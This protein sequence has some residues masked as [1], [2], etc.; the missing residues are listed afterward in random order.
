M[1]PRHIIRPFFVIASLFLL[2]SIPPHTAL[3]QKCDISWAVDADGFW[4][5]ASHWDLNRAPQFGER[6]CIDRPAGDFTI[7]IRQNTGTMESVQSN[8]TLRLTDSAAL[9][10]QQLSMLNGGLLMQSGELNFQSAGEY[11]LYG[12]SIWSG[13][14]LRAPITNRGT[15]TF[16][17]AT[18]LVPRRITLTNQ[19]TIV[20]LDGAIN[21]SSGAGGST[22]VNEAGALYDIRSGVQF[23]GSGNFNNHGTLRKSSGEDEAI[24]AGL[25]F[26]NS[27]EGVVDVQ[28]G[29]LVFDG[30]GRGDG[31]TFTVAENAVLEWRAWGGKHTGLFTGSGDGKIQITGNWEAREEGATLDF[32]AGMLEW[33]AGTIGG[34]T[35][36]GAGCS[37]DTTNAGF[38]TLVGDADKTLIRS[39][40]NTGTIIH[41]GAGN[42][43]LSTFGHG[44]INQAEGL[45][46]LR[47]DADILGGSGSFTNRGILRKTGGSGE[48]RI[49]PYSL[50]NEGGTIDVQSGILN[51][52]SR[53]NS[54]GGHFN[55]EAGA[56]LEFSQDVVSNAIHNM[57]GVYTGAGA[58]TVRHRGYIRGDS[59]NPAVLD[60]PPGMF[61][62]QSGIVTGSFTNSGYFNLVGS[63]PKYFR[64]T[65]VNNGHFLI[66]GEGDWQFYVDAFFTNN[67]LV[68]FQSD[69]NVEMIGVRC[70]GCT[71]TIR[72]NGTLRKSAGA[73]A[74]EWIDPNDY[75]TL[76]LDNVGQVE[77]MSGSLIVRENVVQAVGGRL[78]G[79][80][81][82]ISSTASFDMPAMGNIVTNE[83]NVTLSGPGS[84]FPQINSLT[85]N[86]GRFA[87]DGPRAFV[88]ASTLG[89]Q[90]EL[91]LGAG[92]RLQVTGNYTA[93]TDSQ[94]E[95][96]ITGRPDSGDFGQI[97]VGGQAILDGRLWVALDPGFAPSAGDRYPILTFGERQGDF[98]VKSGLDPHFVTQME[99]DRLLLIAGGAPQPDLAIE[100]VTLV[101]RPSRV[102]ETA[103]VDF[104]VHNLGEALATGEWTDAL[105][106][107][108][109]AALDPS[110]VLLGSLPR[111]GE[112]AAGERYQARIEAPLPSLS[113]GDFHVIAVADHN[114]QVPDPN[115][116]NNRGVAADKIS[117][118]IPTLAFDTILADAIADGQ[119]KYYRLEVPQGGDVRLNV[120]FQTL[121]AAEVYVRRAALPTRATW[122]FT[123]SNLFETERQIV[124]ESPAAGAYYI[125]VYGR[126]GAA[127]G[128][129]LTL[130]ATRVPFALSRIEPLNGSNYGE[131]TISLFGSEFTEASEVHLLA[132]GNTLAAQRIGLLSP[133]R[134]YATFDL[135]DAPTGLY[136]V[137]VRKGAEVAILESRFTVEALGPLGRLQVT[138]NLPSSMRPGRT[139][140]GTIDYRNVGKTD[141]VSP[142][143]L[144]RSKTDSPFNLDQG[145]GTRLN[146]PHLAVFAVSPF[147]PAGI[148]PPGAG[149]T[150][151]VRINAQGPGYVELAAFVA[152]VED[153]SPTVWINVLGLL[154]PPTAGPEWAEVFAERISSY[155]NHVGAYVQAVGAAAELYQ[156]RT[157]ERTHDI[158]R[159]I[160]FT[161]LDGIA[162]R[163]ANLAGHVYLNDMTQPLGKTAVTAVERESGDTFV[164]TTYADGL[165]RFSTLPPGVY[166]LNFDGVLPP[167]NLQP[168]TITGGISST[169]NIWVTRPGGSIVGRIVLPVNVPDVHEEAYAVAISGDLRF[170]ARIA[171]NGIFEI[172]GL[173]SG[174]YTVEAGSPLA[175]SV[176][177]VEVAVTAPEEA[178]VGALILGEVGRVAGRITNHNGA[179]L[180]GAQIVLAGPAFA[181]STVSD[182]D[183]RYILAGAPVGNHRIAAILSP[184]LPSSVQ[185]VVTPGA[186]TQNVDIILAPAASVVGAIS[187]DSGPVARAVVN[188]WQGG[189]VAGNALSD[190]EG[191]YHFAAMTAGAYTLTVDAFAYAAFSTP[192]QLTANQTTTTDVTLT[193]SAVIS[194]R[195]VEPISGAALSGVTVYLLGED[196]SGQRMASDGQGRFGFSRLAPGA[197]AV[198]LENGAARQTLIV[199]GAATQQITLQLA[200]SSLRGQV[201]DGA[202]KPAPAAAVRLLRNGQEIVQTVTG[203]GGQYLFPFVAPGDY[204]VI[205]T[206]QGAVELVHYPAR[207]LRVEAGVN[208]AAPDLQPGGQ[209]LTV[210]IRTPTNTLVT[211]GDLL[212][213]RVLEPGSTNPVELRPLAADGSTLLG[214]LPPG[215]YLLRPLV[216]GWAAEL[217]PVRVDNA[218]V[219]LAITLKESAMLFGAVS[220]GGNQ[221]LAEIDVA[222]YD[223]AQPAS[224]YRAR[225]D[226][227]GIYRMERMP[228]GSYTVVIASLGE[229]SE[230]ADLIP[231]TVAG[232]NLTAGTITE[233]SATLLPGDTRIGGR[234]TGQ[235]GALPLDAVVTLYTATGIVVDRTRAA[236]DGQFTLAGVPPGTFTVTAQAAGYAIQPR[237][238]TVASGQQISDL[239]LQAQWVAWS[240]G[241]GL[242]DEAL[243]A[244]MSRAI[245]QRSVVFR[246][247]RAASGLG[248]LLITDFD[249][250]DWSLFNNQAAA[251]IADAL[252]RLLRKPQAAPHLQRPD[253]LGECQAALAAWRETQ[254]WQNYA[255]RFFDAWVQDWEGVV[256]SNF[257]DAAIMAARGLQLYFTW[258]TLLNDLTTFN[259]VNGPVIQ[260][261]RNQLANT[262]NPATQAA[263]KNSLVQLNQAEVV[264]N[265]I[266]SS[267]VGFGA[268]AGLF[269]A[270]GGAGSVLDA[271]RNAL[272]QGDINSFLRLGAQLTNAAALAGSFADIILGVTRSLPSGLG[273]ALGSLAVVADTVAD[274]ADAW[275]NVTG[276]TNRLSGKQYEYDRAIQKRNAAYQKVLA[277]LQRCDEEE[278]EEPEEPDDEVPPCPNCPPN[279]RA[280]AGIV[281]SWDPNEK[282][283]SGAG[284][285]AHNESQLRFTRPGE[286]INY[287]VYFENLPTAS[288]SAQEV[289]IFDDLDANLDLSTFELGRF[290]FGG[291]EVDA[292]AGRA[293][294][295]AQVDVRATYSL[296]VN[297]EAELDPV[298]RRLSMT[299]R[300]VDPETG[301]LPEDAL[302]GFLPPNDESGRGEGFVSFSIAPLASLAAGAMIRNKAEIIFDA[303]PPIITNQTRNR[304]DGQ[305]PA[306]QIAALPS[307][308]DASF[309]VNW[310]GDDGDGIGVAF[311]TIYVAANGGPW[312]VWQA[313]IETTSA[314][315]TGAVGN[316]YAFYS[317]ATDHLGHREEK[318]PAAEASTIITGEG[319]VSIYLPAISRNQS[320]GQNPAAQEN[321]IYLPAV[322][323]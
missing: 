65:F 118:A 280:T 240:A 277:A 302:A 266:L 322:Q 96:A 272:V 78:T 209:T 137:R 196:G 216:G 207:A 50:N 144:L 163:R 60:F 73:G 5:E 108:A 282:V 307:N 49:G 249:W 296:Y 264:A 127:R 179:P 242:A 259:G 89:N 270:G 224:V 126:E 295:S 213:E 303:N 252:N 246:T 186:T 154:R 168:I 320:S 54:T 189:D 271:F 86:R 192:I 15:F 294:H 308:S 226:A 292:P 181:R 152:T 120:I 255:N 175:Q 231:H 164:A 279:G 201:L 3:A 79:G 300:A 157:G 254:I 315:F 119:S 135:R 51:L 12:S 161:M 142:I 274:A 251:A 61:Q 146:R 256:Q 27:A 70:T 113:T 248:D 42:L 71:P 107:S 178:S 298:A 305:P 56:V 106:L 253:N 247:G 184:Y 287:T 62:W 45:Y 124:M 173:P 147:G 41:T 48:S 125:L 314:L 82:V 162:E 260:E 34:G 151:P 323:R 145:I 85:L 176:Q 262:A 227:A 100:S 22:I 75:G 97:N 319:G 167:A 204:T 99:A 171:P 149:G 306:S 321:A 33:V 311:Y 210:Q 2:W 275:R 19:D 200:A 203:P 69:A 117:M 208:A 81:W 229:E 214:G 14:Q 35:C 29:R 317:E 77:V 59:A 43:T 98:A 143:I 7:T 223:L 153:H 63:E 278:D 177:M 110:D 318:T 114:R 150:I 185:A 299:L 52:A 129:P 156:Q 93:T 180:S 220:D 301:E 24:V 38:L 304:M 91:A 261:L 206:V 88:T 198:M 217:I 133:N 235:G 40:F 309:Q 148:L 155:G 172:G 316:R 4:D 21:D 313:G 284:T 225:T 212:L 47:S 1:V 8:E 234:L 128:T 232:V 16:T 243:R 23:L 258:Q 11:V 105:F 74:S 286:R 58:G 30:S 132:T 193:A 281:S 6:V 222:V 26:N 194:G 265:N 228:P 109:D 90:G 159:L 32:P 10:V 121:H 166:D 136:S 230:R 293:Y 46:E 188:L 285:P 130:R 138:V 219:D 20:H 72:N 83:A 205:A 9:R 44:I 28:S 17:S 199:T 39:I 195:V 134:L 312:E 123:A 165:A 102:G 66:V 68:D 131:V 187:G 190:E 289:F 101:N 202:G 244:A 55:V 211:E 95:I 288:A 238:V 283:G 13:G 273:A 64:S 115:R 268:G 36:G 215:E 169:S 170:E 53:G 183:G 122:D 116:D 221:P 92:S 94:I 57:T 276:N 291:L 37:G 139:Y 160:A 233:V 197:Y 141:L 76:R 80:V 25:R 290:G 191:R 158:N 104:V 239:E 267:L 236:V 111:R 269:Q 250:S 67:G 18:E 31:G 84:Q 182:A 87:L 112:L 241:Q 263:I 218:S 174:V 103:I 257:A 140:R 297:F 245:P 310:N 237:Q